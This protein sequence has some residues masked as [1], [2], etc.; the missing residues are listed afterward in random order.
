MQ[1]VTSSCYEGCTGGRY[2]SMYMCVS[3]VMLLS[4]A[5]PLIELKHCRNVATVAYIAWIARAVIAWAHF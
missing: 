4:L 5:P 2:I 3:K 1:A